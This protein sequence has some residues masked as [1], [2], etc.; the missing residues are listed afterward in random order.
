MKRITVLIGLFAGFSTIA[1]PDTSIYDLPKDDFL[2]NP[3][4]NAIDLDKEFWTDEPVKET[5][6]NLSGGRTIMGPDPDNNNTGNGQGQSTAVQQRKTRILDLYPNPN[7]GSFHMDF[8]ELEGKDVEVA[9]Y[10][11]TGSLIHQEKIAAGSSPGVHRLDLSGVTPGIYVL[12]II[13]NDGDYMT[14]K[15]Q[16]N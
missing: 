4:S 3:G 2:V 11:I 12:Q 6:G 5:K 9:I 7:S 10:N 16:I 14:R 8:G 1:Q 15:F 13:T